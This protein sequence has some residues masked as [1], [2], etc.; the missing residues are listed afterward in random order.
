MPWMEELG[1]DGGEVVGEEWK[2]EGEEG[3]VA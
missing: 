3:K 2:M 1:Q